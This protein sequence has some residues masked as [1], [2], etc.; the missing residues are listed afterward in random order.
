MSTSKTFNQLKVLI[1]N[2][3]YKTYEDMAAKLDIFLMGDR[4]S[5]IEYNELLQLLKT[6][7]YDSRL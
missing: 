3:R 1:E 6:K 5:S 2:G 4:I 7:D